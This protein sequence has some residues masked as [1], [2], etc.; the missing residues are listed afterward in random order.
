MRHELIEEI[1]SIVHDVISDIS[2][3]PKRGMIRLYR[4]LTNKWNESYPNSHADSPIG[5][6]T[7]TDTYELARAYAGPDGYVY[8]LDLPKAIKGDNYIDENPRS[9]TYGDRTLYYFNG[10][11]ADLNG[12]HGREVLV[13]DDHELWDDHDFK[14]KRM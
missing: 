11:A 14:I 5:Y 4:G 6:S 12:A 1:R 8:Y 10:K 9:D 7:W 3:S 13:Y 2:S